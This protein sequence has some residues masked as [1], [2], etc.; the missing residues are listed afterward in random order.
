MPDTDL[1]PALNAARIARHAKAA[2][3]LATIPFA[4]LANIIDALPT[5]KMIRD[6]EPVRDYVPG[7]WPTVGDARRLRD[8]LVRL[9]WKP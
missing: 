5:A 1:T 6:D 8:E 9:G 4:R 2:V 7:A 3:I